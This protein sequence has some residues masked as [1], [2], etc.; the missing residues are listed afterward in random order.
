MSKKKEKKEKVTY[1][2]DGI[3]IADMSGIGSRRSAPPKSRPRSTFKEHWQTYWMAV[4]MMILPML[5]VLGILGLTYL[6]MYFALTAA[7]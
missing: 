3:T 7:R 5:V 2:D 1:V 6:I 4:R